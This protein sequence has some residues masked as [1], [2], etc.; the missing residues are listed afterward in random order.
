MLTKSRSLQSHRTENKTHYKVETIKRQSR[1]IRLDAS[2]SPWARVR[3][4]A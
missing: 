3:A 2:Q 4:S 1:A